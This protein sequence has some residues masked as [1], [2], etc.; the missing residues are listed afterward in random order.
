MAVRPGSDLIRRRW[1]TDKLLSKSSVSF[2][3]PYTGKDSN[4]IIYQE[5]DGTCKEGHTVVFDFSAYLTGKS[6]RGSGEANSKSENKRKFSDKLTVDMFSWYVNNGSKF[7]ACDIGDL[8]LPQ[9]ESSVSDLG[10]LYI[11]H[12]DQARFD[13]LQGATIDA[14]APSHVFYLGNDFSWDDCLDIENAAKKGTG[15]FKTTN[16]IVSTE[17]APK[18]APLKGW[19]THNGTPVFL[20]I[21]DNV[22]ATSLKKDPKYQLIK[23]NAD[24]RGNNNS[25]ISGLLGKE[26]NVLYVEAPVFF[27][28][29]SPGEFR[30][31]DDT[32]LEFSGLRRYAVGKEGKQIWEGQPGFDAIEALSIDEKAIIDAE[33]DVGVKNELIK[34]RENKVYS[35]GLLLGAGASREA[36]GQMPK[37]DVEWTKF[38][39]TSESML[40]IIYNTAKTNLSVEMG[41]DY[42][43]KVSDIDFGVIALDME[44]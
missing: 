41:S 39:K 11:R 28:L 3:A 9:H 15:L 17:L 30:I 21:I 20:A 43:G 33:T 16:G 29:T 32:E 36:F 23:M 5:S 44:N 13:T 37:Y 1:T 6:T 8:E 35:R 2:F 4:S 40:E 25:L 34:N 27:G 10:D 26:S 42:A 12:R 18:R 24:V 31:M 19:K 38:K 14:G 7:E 22:M